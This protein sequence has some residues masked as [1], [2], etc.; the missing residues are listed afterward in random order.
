M[1][2]EQDGL[3]EENKDRKRHV[4]IKPVNIGK[5]MYNV[6]QSENKDRKRHVPIEPVNI[7]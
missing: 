7:G 3:Q 5:I 6:Q 1:K 2:Q 4:P